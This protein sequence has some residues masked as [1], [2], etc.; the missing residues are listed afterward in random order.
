MTINVYAKSD[1]SLAFIEKLTRKKL[2]L[3]LFLW[4]I[5]ESDDIS[6]TDFAKRLGISRQYLCDLERGRRFMSAKMAA[7]FAKKLGYS[8]IQFI[9][10]AFQDELN[11]C[12]LR[13]KIDIKE[14]KAA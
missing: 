4:A 2:T 10:L 7:G 8:P 6:Q 14:Q 5:R 11:K 13:F 12:G 9:R 1:Q 3:G